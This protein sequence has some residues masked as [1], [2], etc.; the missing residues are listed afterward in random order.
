MSA[1]N[2]TPE[3]VFMHPLLDTV[4][5][6]TGSR[7]NILRTNTVDLGELPAAICKV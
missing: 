2:E 4:S 3:L 1:F 5:I 6:S 7:C